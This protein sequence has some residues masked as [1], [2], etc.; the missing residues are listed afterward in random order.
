MDTL[1]TTT[2]IA[3]IGMAGR[4]PGAR[5]INEYWHN[6]ENGIESITYF[7]DEELR[8][9]GVDPVLLKNPHYVKAAP[10]LEDFDSFDASFFNY[11][12][13]EARIMDPQQ[14]VFLECA[15]EALESA[16]YAGDLCPAS[17]GVFAGS[18]GLMS[19]YLLSESH[20]NHRLI[21]ATASTEHT[22][23]DKDYLSTR[24]SFKLNLQ[25]PSL[26]VQTACSTS[27]VAVH[28]A[29]Q[30]L[31]QGECDMALAGGVTIRVPHRTG[32]IHEEGGIFSPD[33]HC[34][35]F[36]ADAKGTT[37]GSGVG[38][39]ILKS[40]SSAQADGDN[41]LAVIKGS[42]INNDGSDKISYW[43][44]SADGQT[45]VILDAL[46][47]AGVDA[48]TIDYVETHGTGTD[49]GD[50]VEV[51]GL[52]RAYREYTDKKGYCAI[53]SVKTNIGHLEAAAGVAG[54]I[55][56]VLAL[57]H[58]TLP[59]HLNFNR[60]NP[61]I[62]FGNN[63][64]YVN[65]EKK[66]WTNGI[67]ARRAAVSSL[68]VG[69][70]NAH[71]IL[72][73]APAH[74]GASNGKGT[75]ER[76]LHLFTLSAKSEAALNLL[77]QSYE[78]HLT[79]YPELEI[80][81]VCFTA[82]TG[83]DHHGHRLALTA[84]S[85]KEAES[86]IQAFNKGNS[87]GIYH[88]KIDK[89]QD[90]GLVFLFTGQGSQYEGMGLQL[91]KTQSTFRKTLEHCAEILRPH[92]DRP[93]IDII[94]PDLKDNPDNSNSGSRPAHL[95][96]T[97]YTQ[98]ALFALEYY[99]V[100]M[101]KSWGI[102]P[103]AVMGHSVGEYVAACAAGVF[104][105]KDALKLIAERGRLMQELPQQGGMAVLFT[106]EERV[107]EVI[108]PY[109]KEIAIAAINGPG[110]IVISGQLESLDVVIEK[111]KKDSV[112]T[113]K[114]E[115]SHAFHS[116]LMN[117]MLK[118]FEKV[119]KEIEYSP[120][121]IDLF[122]NLT[123]ELI[124]NKVATPNYWVNHVAQRVQFARG[125]NAIYEKG[126]RI[127]L[128]IGP[129]PD[130]LGMGRHCLP[131]N[132]NTWLPTLRPQKEDW[133][134][135]LESL[136]QL[137]T[138]GVNVDWVN[139]DRDYSRHRQLLPTYPFKRMRFWIDAAT[140][141]TLHPQNA[142]PL[143]GRRLSLPFSKEIRYQSIFS[144]EAPV[145]LNDH[146][147]YKNVVVPAAAYTSMLLSAVKEAFSSDSCLLADMYFPEALVIPDHGRQPMQL[148][149]GSEEDGGV[150]FQV[151]S[152]QQGIN[153][154]DF[155]SCSVHAS[156]RL[157]LAPV[158]VTD[159]GN[160]RIELEEIK[161]RCEEYLSGAD[162][163]SRFWD[164]GYHLGN[165]FRWLN[166]IWRGEGELLC[167]MECS[168]LVDGPEQYQLHAGLIDSCFQL[169]LVDEINTMIE[170]NT[171]FVPFTINGFRF[172]GLPAHGSQLWCHVRL[173]DKE[174]RSGQRL[175]ADVELFDDS[176]RVIAEIEGLE[177][178]KADRNALFRSLEND[179][180]DWLYREEWQPKDMESVPEPATLSESGKWII[181]ADRDG[182]GKRLAELIGD[183]AILV[184]P[185][186]R[187][188]N[189]KGSHY[190]VNPL[191]RE[192]FQRLLEEVTHNSPC[193]GIV[194]LWSLDETSRMDTHN[195]LQNAQVLGCGSVL[196][197]VQA[198]YKTGWSEYPEI[199][200]VT[201]GAIN[202]GFSKE[203]VQLQQAPIWGMSRVI[204]LEIPDLQCLRVDLDPADE[205]D[206]VQ[207]LYKEL[208]STD[209]EDQVAWRQG[210]RHVAR[211]ARYPSRATAGKFEFKEDSSYLI[212]GGL[213][214]LGQCVAQ[215]MVEQGARN[216]ILV[217]R[218]GTEQTGGL[219]SIQYLE[220]LGARVLVQKCDVSN[221]HDVATMLGSIEREMPPLRGVIHA[222]GI[223][224]D[225][226][227]LQQNWE[228]FL[229][230][231]APKMEGAWNL[232]QFT[233]DIALDFF[234]C[235]SSVASLYGTL[236]QS[237][238]AAANAFMDA[239]AHYRQSLGLPGLSINWGPWSETGMAATMDEGSKRR[240]RD[241]G[242]DS[243]VPSS[244]LQ[245]LDYLIGQECAQVGV[246]PTNWTKLLQQ[247][248]KSSQPPFFEN[249][250]IKDELPAQKS[251]EFIKE[252][253]IVTLSKRRELILS[254]VCF[255]VT[256]V[257]G[258][259][260]TDSINFQQGFFDM[261]MDSLSSMD[262]R[263]NLQT[264]LGRSFPP[265]L[266]LN[267]P[268][269]DSLV[270]FLTE[271]FTPQEVLDSSEP[272]MPEDEELDTFLADIEQ[273]SDSEI[274]KKLSDLS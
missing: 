189:I 149:L 92:L 123:G 87:T 153:E 13:R 168:E 112:R 194:H 35:A 30:S 175:I 54:L 195:A 39:V 267:Y 138:C 11:S 270:D 120:P 107:N 36:D 201:R 47:F 114:L 216:L 151:V 222:A 118:A 8:K 128:E 169:M 85:A 230:V 86:K 67:S 272:A 80:A 200:L 102:E 131:H 192:D 273:M 269:V 5:N 122:S 143:L 178:R 46:D 225:G 184:Y 124:T 50:P 129:K 238:Y 199:A 29:C 150:P 181:L 152:L 208:C 190:V 24:V 32:Y 45:K 133:Q 78:D 132:S 165:S 52:T 237:T 126:N 42:A 89:E 119:A 214:A 96:E 21:G 256:S 209:R 202:T 115:V 268:T 174:S 10:I 212:T 258:L 49:L 90:T 146:R 265:T 211:L 81:D 31:L 139:F 104:E 16:G 113:K 14:R 73:E 207:E 95:T 197:L 203:S 69:G 136:G 74:N 182:S 156:G 249:F 215:W 109:D 75:K 186:E 170:N 159:S 204:A 220:Q 164:A 125:M 228:Q 51:F 62:D 140:S 188:D 251:L 167:R 147:L 70:T 231:M 111:L 183:N 154:N 161:G 187:Y 262:L 145:F 17:T 158:E 232:H 255:Q 241:R 242:L 41:I 266:A 246:Q 247:L 224:E 162:F 68:G 33:G 18:G 205:C 9:T 2:D 252:L 93:L 223:I 233:K 177:G 58:K 235:F 221:P 179:F 135:I 274:K 22:G 28:L 71:V 84:H 64:F 19:S 101:W 65:V 130:L 213:G 260:P 226:V 76:P 166:T 217:G 210:T 257:L 160:N 236:G 218:R 155:T 23:N 60:P 176:G 6:I 1:D 243:I 250:V 15:W 38:I 134:V 137:Y 106:S 63:P 206:E 171:M 37:F 98:P 116:P 72:E 3:I 88:K 53:G 191:V 20:I 55:K 82:N 44:A 173:R 148:I 26:T 61:R 245:V 59:P 91:Y 94:Y 244:G 263:N 99:L 163:Y 117:P 253:E 157:Q 77:T 4:F 66:E 56:T 97:V 219:S 261:G 25:G 34:R 103:N 83:R 144:P 127:F 259:N 108:Q 40:L 180:S 198:L 27:L 100:E 110:N 248:S 264:T 234:V 105:L 185:G 193:S 254:Q 57:K 121:R 196:N 79:R 271:E 239:L 43:A 7:N 48:G 142:H 229:R 172:F 240:F 12:P 227:L 141:Y